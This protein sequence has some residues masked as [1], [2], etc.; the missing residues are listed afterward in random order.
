M[1]LILVKEQLVLLI[2][3]KIGGFSMQYEKSDRMF[4]YLMSTLK[5]S[6]KGWDYFVNWNKVN[7]NVKSLEVELNILNYLIGKNNIKEELKK[8]L[9][10]YPKVVQALPILIACREKTFKILKSRD[11]QNISF[12][13][14]IY[15]FNK[16]KNLSE[17]EISKIIDFCE[18]TGVLKIIQDKQVKNLVDYVMGVEVG[19][20]S[21]GRK[22]R[23]G[24]AMESLVESYIK[25][26]CK[27]H[28]Y[29]YISQA[30][31][32]SIKEKWDL[33]VKVDKASRRFDF[34]IKTNRRLI[35]IETNYYSSGGSKL[36]ATAGEYK[37]L[38][39]LI[40]SDGHELIWITDGL[41]WI[42]ASKSLQETFEHNNYILNLTM[43]Q[44]GMLEDII[45]EK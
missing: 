17:E 3:I 9:T 15:E 45:T 2:E 8:L 26:L 40:T 24:T 29:E 23:S 42:T 34:A 33:E 11:K 4:N 5:D 22:N 21:N 25:D 27:K 36:K 20:D 37:T 6:I 14:E 38:Q 7:F 35:L 39:D 31:P 12:E 16:N 19:L 10:E 41:G 43:I 30:T 28:E 18:N 32:K 44:D 13:N 1:K